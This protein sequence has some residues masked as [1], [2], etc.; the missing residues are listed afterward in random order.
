MSHTSQMNTRGDA[1]AQGHSAGELVKQTTERVSTLVRDELVWAAVNRG[2]A[3]NTCRLTGCWPS[4][5]SADQA[6]EQAEGK[7]A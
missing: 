6:K 4:E 3:G 7:R 1:A 2:A 5:D